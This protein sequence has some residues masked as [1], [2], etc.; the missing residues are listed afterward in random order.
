MDN[1]IVQICEFKTGWDIWRT[2]E[3]HFLRSTDYV[4]LERKAHELLNA[5]LAI[6]RMLAEAKDISKQFSGITVT[7]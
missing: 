5:G 1:F 4:L 2:V 3:R 6:E 7:P